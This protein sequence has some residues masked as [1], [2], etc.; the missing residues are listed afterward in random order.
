MNRGGIKQGFIG[1]AGSRIPLA[2]AAI[3]GG[4]GLSMLAYPSLV[5]TDDPVFG[6]LDRRGNMAYCGDITRSGNRNAYDEGADGN[7]GT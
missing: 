5:E 6:I 1:V 2:T 4:R 7:E 3:R